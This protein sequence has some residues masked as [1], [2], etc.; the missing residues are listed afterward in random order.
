M[1]ENL[2]ENL[3][4]NMDADQ[5]SKLFKSRK[6]RYAT[7]AF[8]DL[9][10]QLRGKTVNASKLLSAFPAGVPFSPLNMMLDY[11]DHPMFPRGYLSPDQD[12]GDNDCDIDWQRPRALPFEDAEASMFFFAQFAEGTQGAGWDPRGIYSNVQTKAA[13]A[14]FTPVYGLEYEYRL[15]RETPDTLRSKHFTD[16]QLVSPVSTYGGVMHQSVWSD[17]FKEMRNMCDEMEVKVASMHWEVAASMGEVALAHQAG[18]AALDDAILFKT[19]AK[20]LAKHHDLT[21]TFMARPLADDDGQSGHVHL[22]LL[23]AH[24]KNAFYDQ[25]SE[26]GMSEVQRHFVGGV[27]KLLPELLLMM[28]PNINSFKR[29]VPGIFAPTAADWGV[30]NRTTAMRVIPGSESSQRLELRVPGSDS[31]PYLVAAAL[32]AAGLH[33]ISNKLEPGNPVSGAAHLKKDRAKKLRFPAGFAEAIERFQK[34][35]LAREAFG[36]DFVEM[37]AGTRRAQLSQFNKM[38]T[39]KELERFLELA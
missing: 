6:A 34:S 12:I 38:V 4:G 35:A 36:N 22:S 17:F 26:H 27:Q 23:D 14:G 24:G 25:A 2:N 10:G 16:I 37:F 21:L 39:D 11:G 7:V 18:I 29:F 28:A 33:G 31:N 5:I 1:N 19:H 9:Q 32:L 30:D 15:L 3:N 20:V 8:V 13:E